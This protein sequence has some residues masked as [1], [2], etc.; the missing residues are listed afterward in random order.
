MSV[1]R[2]LR[3]G[4]ILHGASGNMSAWRHPSATAD[5]S[6]N[7]DFATETARKAEQGK[8]DFLFV[9]DGLYINEKSIPHFLNRFEPLTL[10]SAL[11]GATRH[12]G[13]VGTVSTSYS[14]P[15]TVARQFASLDHL[16]GGRAGW[17]VVT[18]PL[19]GSAKNF[20]RQQHPEHGLRYRIA[21]EYLDVVKGLWDSWEEGA[22]IRDKQ[23]GVFFDKE[24][25]HTLNHHGEFFDVAGPLN[26]GR[27]P[28]GRPVVFQA[29]ASRDGKA[30]AARH[31]DAIFTH[32]KTPDEARAFYRDVKSQLA[33]Y[34]R[35]P[36]QLH[37]FQGVS[38][39]IGDDADDAERQYQQTAA[40]VSIEDALNY[41]GRYFEHHDFSQY[42]LDAPFPE[43]GE[44]GGNSF[45][46]TTD[47]IKQNARERGLTLRQAA[48]EAATPRPV[49]SGTAE[50]VADGLQFWFESGAADGFI[51]NGGTPEVFARF[52]DEVIPLLQQRGLFRRDYP[53]ST[54][55]DSFAL[56]PPVNQFQSAPQV[57][58][59]L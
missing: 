30:L 44:L 39:I 49:F 28:Q 35:S 23:S 13:L 51:I 12:L 56:H 29:G 43:L 52:V 16:S 41:L 58:E 9:A 34:Q 59:A 26:I 38:V 5:A 48:L 57:Q 19:E 40:L 55:R 22:F 11:A 53:G 18:S 7:I 1:K 14:D 21:S 10:L 42:P 25:L 47:E 4:T 15:F 31:A 50:Q 8:L 2:Q 20:S 17:N 45:R 6:I 33:E 54:L 37:I 24:K 32:Q 36:D 27:T 3:L 46:S